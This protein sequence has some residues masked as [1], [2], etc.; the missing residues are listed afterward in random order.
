MAGIWLPFG[1]HLVVASNCVTWLQM[2]GSLKHFPK[3]VDKAWDLGAAPR[4]SRR[5][6]G[7]LS[8]KLWFIDVY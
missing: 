1:C 6:A 7:D 2:T 4:I 8:Q 3:E 5:E